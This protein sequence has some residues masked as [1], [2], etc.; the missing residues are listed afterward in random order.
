MITGCKLNTKLLSNYYNNNPSD[1]TWEGFYAYQPTNSVNVKRITITI[2][3]ATPDL[4]QIFSEND[5]FLQS[6]RKY[7]L[8]TYTE[9]YLDSVF[10]GPS[11]KTLLELQNKKTFYFPYSNT[12]KIVNITSLNV[13]YDIYNDPIGINL[14]GANKDIIF[15][16][17]YGNPVD[18]QNIFRLSYV[19]KFY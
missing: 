10:F 1:P 14:V 9:Q 6:I 2:I 16:N 13:E 12:I 19:L 15:C 7:N 17:I 8:N 11:R 18:K 4:T 3:S 5:I